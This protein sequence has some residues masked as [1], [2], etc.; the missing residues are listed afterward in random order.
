MSIEYCVYY[1]K[2]GERCIVS[3]DDP[4][5]YRQKLPPGAKWDYPDEVKLVSR[6]LIKRVKNVDEMTKEDWNRYG[7]GFR[8]AAKDIPLSR[9][10]PKESN[11]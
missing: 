9:A 4:A 10:M 8:Y 6:P 3:Y 5:R 11:C 1:G 2:N 7:H